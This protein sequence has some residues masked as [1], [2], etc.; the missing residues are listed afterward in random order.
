MAACESSR[1][2]AKTRITAGSQGWLLSRLPEK[3]MMSSSWAFTNIVPIPATSRMGRAHARRERRRRQGFVR[4]GHEGEHD[5]HGG[6]EHEGDDRR[7]RVIT[8]S[9][10]MPTLQLIAVA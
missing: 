6:Q 7:P 10:I 4:R 1:V 5:D 3:L 8:E 9:V 2:E